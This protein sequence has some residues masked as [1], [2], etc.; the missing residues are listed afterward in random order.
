M[1]EAFAILQELPVI[2]YY[3][4]FYETGVSLPIEYLP[5]PLCPDISLKAMSKDSWLPLHSIEV[6]GR[7]GCLVSSECRS[8][9]CYRT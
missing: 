2:Q 8:S 3:L 9:C 7:G 6:P 4:K 1:H 5:L